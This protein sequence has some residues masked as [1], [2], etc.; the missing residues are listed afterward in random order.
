MKSKPVLF[1]NNVVILEDGR[2]YRLF[3][4]EWLQIDSVPVDRFEVQKEE[5]KNNRG[6]E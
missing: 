2:A 6:N 4:S 1:D 3:G 5:T